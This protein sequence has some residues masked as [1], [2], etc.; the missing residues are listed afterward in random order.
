MPR[1][2]A[3]T[4][5]L[6]AALAALAGCNAQPAEQQPMEQ[7]TVAPGQAGADGGGTYSDI[8]PDQRSAAP[9][10]PTKVEPQSDAHAA[11]GD[12]VPRGEEVAGETAPGA[13]GGY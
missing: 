1:P 9:A 12:A 4:L 10:A 7:P 5:A 8:P 13:K 2:A 3:P 6:A 11:A